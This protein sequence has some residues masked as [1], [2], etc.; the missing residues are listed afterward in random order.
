[1]CFVV[2]TKRLLC[3]QSGRRMIALV[4]WWTNCCLATTHT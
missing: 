3:R 1:M 2:D 4:R